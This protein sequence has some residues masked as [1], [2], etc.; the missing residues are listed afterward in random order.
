ME[1][2][3][4]LLR[5]QLWPEL[6]H[7]A[8]D[9]RDRVLTAASAKALRDWRSWPVPVACGLCAWACAALGLWGAKV[10][11]PV[12][13]TQLPAWLAVGIIPIPLAF[14][15]AFLRVLRPFVR[16]ELPAHCRHCGYDL[17]GNRSGTCPECGTRAA[18]RGP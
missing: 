12:L 13:D 6:S 18:A 3:S 17:T 8:P 1:C 16:R 10:V 4:F 15:L 11:H 2:V 5:D 7:L 14:H 9:E